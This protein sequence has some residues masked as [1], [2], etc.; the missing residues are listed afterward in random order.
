MLILHLVREEEEE[1]RRRSLFRILHALNTIHKEVG[2]EE[3]EVEEEEEFI[4]NRTRAGA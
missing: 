4:Q 3:E 1:G 2:L